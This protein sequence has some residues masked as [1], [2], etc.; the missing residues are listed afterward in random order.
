MIALPLRTRAWHLLCVVVVVLCLQRVSSDAVVLPSDYY[1]LVPDRSVRHS[2][3]PS[4]HGGADV[5]QPPTHIYP[6]VQHIELLHLQVSSASP[7]LRLWTTAPLPTLVISRPVSHPSLLLPTPCALSPAPPT[8]FAC[9]T[10]AMSALPVL[11]SLS[12][13]LCLRTSL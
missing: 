5:R 10:S 11:S 12:P 3:S 9:P 8:K 1:S 4:L 2:W 6:G 13:P 7:H